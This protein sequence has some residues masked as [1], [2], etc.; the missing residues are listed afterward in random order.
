MKKA[1]LLLSLTIAASALFGQSQRLVL[2]EEFTQASCGPCAQQNPAFNSLLSANTTKAVSIKYQTSWPGTDPMNAQTA[3][4]VANRV[5][6]Y[7]VNSVPN[8]IQDGVVKG[9]PSNVTQ[10]GIDAEYAVTSPFTMQL[11]HWFNAANDSI[12][13]NCEITCTQNVT[14]TTPRVRIAMIEKTITFTTAPGTNGEKVFY[15]VMRKMYPN[16]NGTA[17]ATGAWTVGQ[18]KVVSFKAAIPSYIYSKPQIAVLGWIQDDANKSV[19]QAGY[20]SA[21]GTPVAQAPIADFSADMLTSCDGIIKFQ[22]QSALFPTSW[23]WEFGDGTTA[24]QSKP[25]HKYN[26][27]GTYSVKLTATNNSG[28]NTATKTSY[29]TVNLAGAAP[30]GVNGTRC[31]PGVVNL[32]AQPAG[33]GT[34]NW[35]NEAGQLVNTGTTYSPT[36]G[37]PTAS[38]NFYVAEMTANPVLSNGEPDSSLGVGAFFTANNAHGLFFDVLKPSTIVSVVVYAN[39]AGNR[40]IAVIDANGATVQSAVKNIPAGRSVVTLNFAMVVGTGYYMKVASTTVGLYRNQGGATYPY[41]SGVVNI[42]G[43]DAG[44]NYYFFYDWRVQQNPCASPS[45][46]V[47]GKDSC[48]TTGVADISLSNS[49]TVFPNPSNGVFTANFQAP[50]ADN[51]TVRITNTL[52]QIV[53]EEALNNF[54]GNYSKQMDITSFAKGAYVLI[55]SNSQNESVKQVVV[56]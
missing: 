2:V 54:S 3:A 8:A 35:Y 44:L 16:A 30:T 37:S 38:T 42:T 47:I 49:L 40:T 25:T 53:Y 9:T 14:M 20:S 31:G 1:S 18:K 48:S 36:I 11:T 29:V 13:I 24:T 4:E 46:I 34:L 21:P 7:A 50:N 22:D 33:S 41:N 52:G 17:L 56:Y 26:S 51:Y 6:Y 23:L 15:N 32:S 43:S 45:T 10:A 12:F 5:T 19:K 27:S 39:T 28:T 55:V